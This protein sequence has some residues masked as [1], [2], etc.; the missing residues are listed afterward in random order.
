MTICYPHR[1]SR[2][3]ALSGRAG[4]QRAQPFAGARGV[5]APLP[6]LSAAGGKKKECNSPDRR[7]WWAS[8]KLDQ[9]DIIAYIAYLS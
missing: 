5:L 6:L 2:A 3:V 4:V 7:R 8:S 9:R 1:R